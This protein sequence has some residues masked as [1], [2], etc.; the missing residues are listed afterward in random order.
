MLNS[1]L[2]QTIILIKHSKKSIFKEKEKEK[3][4]KPYDGVF[5]WNP[6]SCNTQ[7]PYTPPAPTNPILST[8]KPVKQK[9]FSKDWSY[10]HQNSPK[11]NEYLRLG[12]EISELIELR[13][14]LSW[15]DSTRVLWRRRIGLAS[16]RFHRPLRGNG[17]ELSPDLIGDSHLLLDA[18]HDVAPAWLVLRAPPC[19]H[20]GVLLLRSVLVW[21]DSSLDLWFVFGGGLKY[22]LVG[23]REE[24]KPGN[25]GR[26]KV[27]KSYKYLDLS[28]T[29]FLYRFE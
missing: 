17:I 27:W 15:G 9:H 20:G 19:R 24:D 21:F 12:L 4:S 25:H 6:T 14:C 23:T 18:Q 11:K 13:N 8:V 16:V 28:R 10:P 22:Y 26:S 3:K 5:Q 1:N 7:S 2:K 29:F